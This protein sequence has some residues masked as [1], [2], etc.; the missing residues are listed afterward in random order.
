MYFAINSKS[1]K[2]KRCEGK[3]CFS[4][5][6]IFSRSSFIRKQ[7][8]LVL[9]F[10]FSVLLRCNRCFHFLL[11]MFCGKLNYPNFQRNLAISVCVLP[12]GFHL[13]NARHPSLFHRITKLSKKQNTP[14]EFCIIKIKIT[15]CFTNKTYF[16]ILLSTTSPQSEIQT[17]L[18]L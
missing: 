8:I 14:K 18:T 3:W 10:Q 5:F 2:D 6:P 15:P 9:I 13:R 7:T 11:K 12:R 4:R 16:D 1:P 17:K